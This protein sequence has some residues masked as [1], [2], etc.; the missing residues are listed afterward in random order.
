M[1]ETEWRVC[2]DPSPMITWVFDN[3]FHRRKLRLF[4]CACCRRIESLLTDARSRRAVEMAEMVADASGLRDELDSAH[5]AADRVVEELPAWHHRKAARGA[6]L[7]A[8]RWPGGT[9]GHT[10]LSP[11]AQKDHIRVSVE[12]TAHAAAQ[13]MAFASGVQ[14]E[15]YLSERQAQASLIRDIF[16]NP[17]RESMADRDWLTSTVLNL[18]QAIYNDR[19]FDRLPILADALEDAGCTNRDILNHCHQPGEHVRGC[20]VV[21]L[22]LGKS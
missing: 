21:D 1:T 19:V 20:W 12:G 9:P 5:S 13:A 14:Q 17:Y 10:W 3:R 2:D 11:A 8:M 7:C 16:G 18:A 4:A 6:E 15:A 22:L